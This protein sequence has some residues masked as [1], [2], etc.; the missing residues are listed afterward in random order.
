[1]EEVRF[2]RH[3]KRK[4]E[5]DQPDTLRVDYLC[6][7]SAGGMPETISEWVC[8]EHQGFARKKAR[9]WWAE[10][11]LAPVGGIRDALDLWGRGAFA[12]PT[13]LMARKEGRFWRIV[14]Q[15]LDERPAEWLEAAPAEVFE[16]VA[17]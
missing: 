14:S 10:R 5:P 1:M 7:P 9:R 8:L 13:R 11:S 4:A 17:F 6:Q 15:E 16:D 12:S 2:S 3:R